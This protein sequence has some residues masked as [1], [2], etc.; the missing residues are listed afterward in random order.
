MR[1][2]GNGGGGG[3]AADAGDES[4][5]AHHQEAKTPLVVVDDAEIINTLR[6]EYQDELRSGRAAIVRESLLLASHP[7]WRARFDKNS[8]LDQEDIVLTHDPFPSPGETSDV[9]RFRRIEKNRFPDLYCHNVRHLIEYMAQGYPGDPRDKE[10]QYTTE[11][12]RQLR[13]ADKKLATR[14]WKMPSQQRPFRLSTSSSSSM[15]ATSR[16]LAP[17]A[18]SQNPGVLEA[19]MEALRLSREQRA[20]RRA[21]IPTQSTSS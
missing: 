8:C 3:D 19:V 13:A 16:P 7:E 6:R 9:W 15:V 11:S 17:L 12:L 4:D 5:G 2:P 10:A 21:G 14:P 1:R 18:P 20:R